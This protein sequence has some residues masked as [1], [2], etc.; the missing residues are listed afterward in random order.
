VI[1][2]QIDGLLVDFG[3]VPQL[4]Q[5]IRRLVS[6]RAEAVEMG[7]RGRAKVEQFYTW[8]RIHSLLTSIYD[9]LINRQAR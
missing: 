3:N 6:D 9:D 5:A 4:T 2:E 8:D 1:S 7:A